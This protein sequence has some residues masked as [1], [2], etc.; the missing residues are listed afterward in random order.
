ARPSCRIRSPRDSSP[1]P[2]RGGPCRRGSAAVLAGPRPAAATRREL[3]GA[4]APAAGAA[5]PSE[6]FWHDLLE[7]LLVQGQRGADTL[8]AFVRGLPLLAA[9]GVVGF[10]AA[11]RRAPAVESLRAEGQ[12][13]ADRAD[14]Q[15]GGPLDL[16]GAQLG[17]DLRRRVL[18]QQSSARPQGP[19]ET[20]IPPGPVFGEQVRTSGSVSLLEARMLVCRRTKRCI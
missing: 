17:E 18:R 3:P 15:A 13:R 4:S 10:P 5:R 7:Q 1:S 12:L 16:G 20:L 8:A 6:L 14:G 2:G 19:L 9:L 11:V